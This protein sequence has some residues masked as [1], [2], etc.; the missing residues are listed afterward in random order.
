M[1]TLLLVAHIAAVVLFIGPAT[2]AT[3]AFA[4]YAARATRDSALALHQ[5]SRTYGLATLAVPAAGFALAGQQNLLTQGWVLTSAALFLVGFALLYG[6]ILP[7]Q[8]RVLDALDA[9]EAPTPADRSV[10]RA[11]AGGYAVAWVAILVLMVAKPF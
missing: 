1:R 10:L 2:F 8:A 4:R 9:G 7:R 6:V 5:A 11:A 3:S